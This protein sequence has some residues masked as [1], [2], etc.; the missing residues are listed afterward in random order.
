VNV[1][2]TAGVAAGNFDGRLVGFQFDNRLVLGD[3]LA[4]GHQHVQNFSRFDPLA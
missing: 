4:F 3:D 2:D 1:C